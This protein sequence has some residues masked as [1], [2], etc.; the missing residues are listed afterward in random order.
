VSWHPSLTGACPE[1][2]TLPQHYGAD[3]SCIAH[4]RN[5][6]AEYKRAVAI[7]EAHVIT[8]GPAEAEQYWLDKGAEF[9][10]GRHEEQADR[11]RAEAEELY[12]QL[13]EEPW[14]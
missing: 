12:D 1:G 8:L 14:K 11:E 5:F 2:I 6:D 9:S 13:V 3:G 7:E 4:P 10:L